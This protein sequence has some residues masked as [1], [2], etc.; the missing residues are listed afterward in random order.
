MIIQEK[1]ELV[2]EIFNIE[3]AGNYLQFNPMKEG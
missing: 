2:D 3:P 1:E